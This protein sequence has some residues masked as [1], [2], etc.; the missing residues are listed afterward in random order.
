MPP[1]QHAYSTAQRTF[2]TLQVP[3]PSKL[4]LYKDVLEPLLPL[5]G[6]KAIHTKDFKDGQRI[7]TL[8]ELLEAV[9]LSIAGDST[10][11][12][13]FITSDKSTHI[14]STIVQQT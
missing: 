5:D 2:V 1:L 6:A 7:P 9:R 12:G 13:S 11:V 3:T 14:K 10:L 4:P 8:S